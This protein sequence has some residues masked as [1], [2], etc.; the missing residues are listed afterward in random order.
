MSEP[1]A[2][3]IHLHP[4]LQQMHGCGM[5]EY[6]RAKMP[7]VCSFATLPKSVGVAS[8]DLVD[9]EAS[10]R[11]AVLRKED[12]ASGRVGHRSLLEESF[13]QVGRLRP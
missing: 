2:N 8:H 10:Q 9:P 13:E 7:R 4:G 6:V 12:G 11:R 1:I 3:D 5:S